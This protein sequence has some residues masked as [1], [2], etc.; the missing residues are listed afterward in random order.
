VRLRLILLTACG[1]AAL[2]HAYGYLRY[3]DL[4][5]QLG[6]AVAYAALAVLVVVSLGPVPLLVGLGALALASDA[7]AVLTPLDT[8][9]TGGYF[10]Y[11]P[12]A[13]P[14][15]GAVGDMF[16]AH[17]TREA[18]PLLAY[19]AVAL[20]VL[21]LPARRRPALVLAGLAATVAV[22]AW[23]AVRIAG[24]E[25]TTTEALALVAG[26]LLLT[27]LLLAATTV[28]TQRVQAPLVAGG[29]ALTVLV[30]LSALDPEQFTTLAFPSVRVSLTALET[31][32]SWIGGGVV[33]RPYSEYADWLSP[34]LAF[35]QIAAAA[36]VTVGVLAQ[37]R[38]RDAGGAGAGPR[39]HFA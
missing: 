4:P 24:A 3:D 20:A 1:L 35:A 38:Y 34:V 10:S 29:L 15:P 12:L 39:S 36:L 13:G 28:A 33:M 9:T 26:P 18:V 11:Q 37:S 17:L 27:A 2:V 31:V 32:M 23:V 21:R 22:G 25:V 6:A 5:A 30:S 7:V 14:T 19:A 16:V 8:A